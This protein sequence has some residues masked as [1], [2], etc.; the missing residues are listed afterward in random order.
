MTTTTTATADSEIRAFLDSWQ[1]A[2]DARDLPALMAHYTPDVI[3]YDAILAL[4]F[5]GREAYGRHWQACLDLCPGPMH[6]SRHGLRIA[7]AGDVGYCHALVRCG[8]VDAEGR[9]DA[10]WTRMTAGLR[11]VDGRWRIAHEHYSAPFDI[12]TMKVLDLTPD[13]MP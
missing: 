10:H 6:F 12:A 4:Q 11:R 9:E 2:V 5:E 1:Q 7:A 3:A 13:A 8:G